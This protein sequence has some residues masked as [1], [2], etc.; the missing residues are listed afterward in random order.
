MVSYLFSTSADKAFRISVD[1]LQFVFYRVSNVLSRGDLVGM[2]FIYEAVPSHLSLIASTSVSF[3]EIAGIKFSH[4][5]FLPHCRL[6]RHI[7]YLND[8]RCCNH[9]EFV[10]FTSLSSIFNGN[11]RTQPFENSPTLNFHRL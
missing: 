9:C 6:C 8:L 3:Y 2:N 5:A 7:I 10:V 11:S 4:N 1:S